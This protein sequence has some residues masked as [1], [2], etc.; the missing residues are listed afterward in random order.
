M[1]LSSGENFAGCADAVL[2]SHL[3]QF[4]PLK[5]GANNGHVYNKS[6]NGIVP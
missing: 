2:E 4:L 6:E 3:V 5:K 1:Y